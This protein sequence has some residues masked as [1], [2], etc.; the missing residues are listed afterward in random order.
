MAGDV[1]AE[2]AVPVRARLFEH[3]AS[4]LVNTKRHAQIR[5]DFVDGEV[6]RARK[7]TAAEFIWPPEDTHQTKFLFRVLQ[8]CDSPLWILQR[9]ERYAVKALSIIAAV[10]GKP[11][12]VGPADG[13]A[14]LRIELTPPHD[15]EAE[16]GKQHADVDAF[17]FHVANVGCG[18][19]LCRQ[20][21]GEGLA[22]TLRTGESEPVVILFFYRAQFVRIGNRL[23]VN[24]TKR[25]VGSFD[26]HT[27]TKLRRQIIRKQIGWLEHI[28]IRIDALESFSHDQFPPNKHPSQ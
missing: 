24:E 13:G 15:I 12:V 16:G 17:A 14:E 10:V 18:V 23:A 2:F 26:A 28:P 22:P 20:R 27:I 11:T 1:A 6:V 3:S 5:R 7:R 8:L 19:E 9:N 4:T 25:L 21:I